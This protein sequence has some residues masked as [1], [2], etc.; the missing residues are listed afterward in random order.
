M[1]Q[2]DNLQKIFPDDATNT[3]LTS[4]I[5][6]QIVKLGVKKHHFCVG[7]ARLPWAGGAGLGHCL[8]FCRSPNAALESDKAAKPQGRPWG[9]GSCVPAADRLQGLLAA[10]LLFPSSL[11]TPT[12]NSTSWE[13][14]ASWCRGPASQGDEN[15]GSGHHG[16]T[17]SAL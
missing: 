15:S 3:G 8:N 17:G 10:R 2:K 7:K 13:G 5:Y 12:P 4:R 9:P 1:K 14:G 6:K 16:R 11:P